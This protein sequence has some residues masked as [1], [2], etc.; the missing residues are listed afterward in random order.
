MPRILPWVACL[1]TAWLGAP[2]SARGDD[3]EVQH[4]RAVAANPSDL[5]FHLSLASGQSQFHLGDSIELQYTLTTT[6]PDKY[7]MGTRAWDHGRRST[8]ESFVVDNPTDTADPLPD[9]WDVYDELYC[10]DRLHQR[11]SRILGPS[12][13]QTDS[14]ELIQYLRFKRPGS[15]R[16]YAITQQVTHVDAKT[17]FS[18][19]NAGEPLA[20]ENIIE[21]QILPPDPEAI[22]HDLQDISARAK[23][24][25]L[26]TADAL[27]LFGLDSP[28]AG[29]IASQYGIQSNN[30]VLR[31]IALSAVLATDRKTSLG[32]LQQRLRDSRFPVSEDLLLDLALV[33]LLRDHKELN[34]TTLRKGGRLFA[35]KW[36][37]QLLANL[38]AEVDRSLANLDQ[39]EA[40][41][42]ALSIQ[43]LHRLTLRRV[44]SLPLTLPEAEESRLQSLRLASLPDLPQQDLGNEL[45]NFGWVASM[46]RDQLL[47]PLQSMLQKLRFDLGFQRLMLLKQIAAF[48]PQ[49]ARALFVQEVVTGAQPVEIFRLSQ[50]NL[51]GGPEL[52]NP[53]LEILEA[54]RTQEMERVAPFIA[55][56]ATP[57]VLPRVKTIYEIH[58]AG[59]PCLLQV[60]LLSY[61]LRVDPDYAGQQIPA[62]LEA[63]YQRT[64]ACSFQPLLQQMAALRKSPELESLALTALSDQRPKVAATGALYFSAGAFSN[65]A[66]HLLV[67]RLQRLHDKWKD[68]DE[69]TAP[70]E[71]IQL[72]NSGYR[73]LEDALVLAVLN[74]NGNAE[75]VENLKQVLPLCITVFCK[76][77][78]EQRIRLSS[79]D[80]REPPPNLT[81]WRNFLAMTDAD[82]SRILQLPQQQQAEELLE[83]AIL[84]DRLAR[85]L[86]EKEVEHWTGHIVMTDHMK[87]LEWRSRFSNDLRVREANEEINLALEGWPKNKSSVDMLIQR[88][89]EDA[90][91]RPTAVYFLGMLAGRGIETEAV[92]IILLDYARHDSNFEVR[93]WA[94]EGLRFLKTDQALDELFDSFLHDPSEKVR[95]RAG[96]NVA[97]CGVFTRK[98]RIRF[99]PKILA[100]T[101]DPTITG[102]MRSW[103]F[104]ALRDLTDQNLPDDS[105][106]WRKWYQEHGAENLA[107]VEKLNWWEVRGDE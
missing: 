20:S 8:L 77:R 56:F 66:R 61:F 94:V 101:E 58:G 22:T 68:F 79:V 36:R 34:S 74:S 81:T 84:H 38:M 13:S 104:L 95:D 45:L 97:D 107:Q 18:R 100:L 9:F 72:W 64:D 44:C 65:P 88:A 19:E 46:P 53:L 47:P 21:L 12:T 78:L 86:L 76:K 99:I 62:A 106:V 50:L 51:P 80:L 48:D 69:S 10:S 91:Y 23:D 37:A 35:E 31:E 25:K 2:S 7:V 67:D 17:R 43:A 102:Q 85:E 1:L 16:I 49:L 42:R 29:H 5:H 3:F 11:S 32:M 33:Q 98:Q 92:H 4:Q 87:Q 41:V 103:V 14:V 75:D 83:R 96:C 60:G 39:R 24:G 30:A 57:A 73:Q 54:R 89:Q 90:I 40:T 70:P 59:W 82:V 28:E 6:A 105:V 63:S 52:D 71:K 26:T 93:Q 27:R 15:Y 55:V